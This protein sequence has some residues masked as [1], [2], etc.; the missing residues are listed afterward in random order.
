MMEMIIVGVD[1]E[2]KGN[3]LMFI[4]PQSEWK[5]FKNKSQ[6]FAYW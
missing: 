2:G 6:Q 3:K 1:D 4:Y 5:A